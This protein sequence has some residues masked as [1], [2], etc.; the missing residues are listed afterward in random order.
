MTLTPK[1]RQTHSDPDEAQRNL[2]SITQK[3]A[4][5]ISWSDLGQLEHF[6]QFYETD[7]FLLDSVSDFV[8]AGLGSGAA[9]IVIATSAH[10]QGLSQR[11]QANGLD[12]ASAHARG[13]YFTLDAAQALAQILLEGSPDPKQFARIIGGL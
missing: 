9:C 11:L 12:L 13:K 5:P 10:R 4:P 1:R 8:G 3:L 6:V 2:A 7:N